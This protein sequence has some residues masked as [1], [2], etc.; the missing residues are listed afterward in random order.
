M[1]PNTSRVQDFVFTFF[2][3]LPLGAFTGLALW[4]T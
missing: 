3:L 2:G 1:S 4:F